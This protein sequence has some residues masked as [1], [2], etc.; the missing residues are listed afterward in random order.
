MKPVDKK[1][2]GRN[3]NKPSSKSKDKNVK[4]EKKHTPR[5]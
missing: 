4:E 3:V 1:I 5:K 2:S